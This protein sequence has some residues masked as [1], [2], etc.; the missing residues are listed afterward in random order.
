MTRIK[1][2]FTGSSALSEAV[3]LS[4][5]EGLG[6]R[7]VRLS[8][9]LFGPEIGTA[10]V[11]VVNHALTGN[12][13]VTGE[14]GWWQGLIGVGKTIDT[15]HFTV[16]AFNIPGNGYGSN[17][18]IDNY[19]SVSVHDV[20]ALL[21]QGLDGLGVG[22]VFAIIG[23]S[24]GGGMAWHMA[25]LEPE[26]VKHL[27]PIATDYKATDW[28]IAN[29]L[30]QDRI[31]NNSTNPVAD[32]RLHAMLLYRTPQSLQERFNGNASAVENWLTSHGK[33]LE[34]RFTLQAYKL[35]NHLLGTISVDKASLL[36]IRATIHLVA[37]DTDLLFVAAEAKK[38]Y[39][40]LKAAGAKVFYNEIRSVHGHDAFLIEGTQLAGILKP[41][42]SSVA[43]NAG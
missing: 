18:A 24:L 38:T 30:V 39:T 42:F 12:S 2:I 4:K 20:A 17:D 15:R 37:V 28:V 27:I 8:Y 23:G 26:R 21:W 22:E 7:L 35:M 43:V 3:P 13:N 31:L 16:L 11:V 14:G 33:K 29:V 36:S 19:K 41:V 34:Q 10:P 40:Q 25:A 1:Q 9:Q 6:E 32:A 5:G